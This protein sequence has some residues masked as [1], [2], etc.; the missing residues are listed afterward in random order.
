MF[1]QKLFLDNYQ[2][3]VL[4]LKTQKSQTLRSLALK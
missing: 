1:K 3:A 2:G 4:E